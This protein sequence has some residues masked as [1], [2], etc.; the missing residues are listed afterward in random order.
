[1]IRNNTKLIASLGIIAFGLA[2][3][4]AQGSNLDK[5]ALVPTPKKVK[6][7]KQVSLAPTFTIDNRSGLKI[8]T[9]FWLKETLQEKLHWKMSKSKKNA[10]VITIIKRKVEKNNQ[11]YALNIAKNRITIK[12]NNVAAIQLGIGRLIYILN[13]PLVRKC[14]NN[15]LVSPAFQII[16]WPDFK[17]RGMHF[18]LNFTHQPALIRKAFDTLGMLG[19]NMTVLVVGG[20]L[21]T[22]NNPEITEHRVK[23]NIS[24]TPKE[25]K[26]LAAYARSRGLMPIPAI[27]SIGHMGA[28]P[29]IFPIRNKNGKIVAMNIFHK[30]FY[31]KYFKYVDE[32]ADCFG[33]TP[34]FHIGTD[35]FQP[36]VKLFNK[37]TDK[38]PDE[39]YAEFVNKVTEHFAKRNIKTIIWSD[40]L[41]EP[42]KY[43]P[44]ETANGDQ[45]YKTLNKLN[46]DVI[47][48]YWAYTPLIKYE[49]L[50]KLKTNHA[51]W[52][53]P[54]VGKNG[55]HQLSQYAYRKG[56]DVFLGTTWRVLLD[57]QD[58]IIFTAEYAWN[59]SKDTYNPA[60]YNAWNIANF[61]NYQ[62]TAGD[63]KKTVTPI[64]FTAVDKIPKVAYKSLKSFTY[65]GKIQST[66]ISFRP[67]GNG[68][69]GG[70]S[71][72]IIQN[73][74]IKSIGKDS[75]AKTM[76][77]NPVDFSD[78]L[79]VTAFNK[80]RAKGNVIIYNPDFG[81]STKA[82]SWGFEYII[83]NGIV[84]S[85]EARTGNA[86]IPKDGYVI[87]M[88]VAHGFPEMWIRKRLNK[89]DKITLIK[90]ALPGQIKNIESKSGSIKQSTTHIILFISHCLPV[91]EIFSLGY[92][93]LKMTNG[94]TMLY[95]LRKS[96]DKWHWQNE[97]KKI[98]KCWSTWL[99]AQNT[100][101]HPQ[102]PNPMF[103]RIIAVEWK[104]AN[105]TQIPESISLTVSKFGEQG[106]LTLLGGVQF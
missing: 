80:K 40:M 9:L 104:Q 84:E 5:G 96:L 35:E 39:Y 94:K 92:I 58:D 97:P 75:S 23:R 90:K 61:I 45:T 16:D 27:N 69:L 1:M 29:H 88:H 26:E 100:D 38:A 91:E 17:M 63:I 85:I 54:W 57:Y 67:I 74:M 14:K 101:D 6:Q 50:D 105:A 32:I 62:R 22:K 60:N 83:R 42:G 59:A 82:N 103:K 13:M 53:S 28:A 12:G 77:C 11:S 21:E 66:G 44:G 99:V 15:A 4:F 64:S 25:L 19:Y 55:I 41:L 48:N 68:Y 72:V 95:P 47:I 78:G 18:M 76:I 102:K 33:N 37:W 51:V 34:Y 7:G 81:D 46:K 73:N 31:K 56:V 43:H 70:T 20:S 36:A 86:K 93:K 52:A 10:T 89:G 79:N 30:D 65:K 2:T 3:Q 106:G 87:S 8:P 49:G 98:T 71:P 24:W